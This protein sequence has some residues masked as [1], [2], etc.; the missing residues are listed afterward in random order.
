MRSIIIGSSMSLPTEEL[1]FDDCYVHLLRESFPEI[2]WIHRLQRSSSI[3]RL[4][5]EGF[6]ANGWDNLEFFTPDFVILHVGVTDASPRLLPRRKLATKLLNISPLAKP[7][8]KFLRKHSGRKIKYCDLSP[9]QFRNHVEQYVKRC[10]NIGT[11]LIIVE[12]SLAQPKLVK[13]KSPEM[14]KSYELYNNIFREI[15]AAHDD[16]FLVEGLKGEDGLYQ[17]DCIHANAKGQHLFYERLR[18]VI[19]NII[20]EKK[21]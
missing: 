14:D 2:E 21:K 1:K 15:A 6:K 11:K 18:A 3:D 10:E 13:S 4:S 12:I 20:A 5:Q 9:E 7:V 8:Y 19:D 17:T 16:V